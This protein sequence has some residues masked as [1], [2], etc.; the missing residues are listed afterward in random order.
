MYYHVF[1][2]SD[3]M[4]NTPEL[5]V[6]DIVLTGEEANDYRGL[7]ILHTILRIIVEHGGS[8]FIKFKNDVANT[9][10]QVPIHKTELHP[11]P[12]MEME[13][14]ESSTMH[15]QWVMQMLLMRFQSP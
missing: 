8:S 14:D 15:Q 1:P 2:D 13:I 12:D 5:S 6:A 9:P 11:L 7:R 10:D 3:S 4:K